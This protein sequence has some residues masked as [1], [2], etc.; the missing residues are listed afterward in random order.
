MAKEY[1]D[2]AYVSKLAMLDER[3]RKK[4]NTIKKAV[5]SVVIILIVAAVIILITTQFGKKSNALIGTWRYDEY[6]QY[7]FEK[8]G[9][10]KLLVDDATYSYTYTVNGE[11][12]ILDFTDDIVMDCDYTFS[13]NNATLTLVGGTGTDGGNYKLNKE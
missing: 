7:V 5:L 8:D 2:K 10:G 11:K 6:T 12:L 13:I 3:R 1:S 4:R 9:T